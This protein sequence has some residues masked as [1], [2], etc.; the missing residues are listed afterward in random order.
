MTDQITDKYIDECKQIHQNAL[1]TAQ[2]HHDRAQFF[3][4]LAFWLQLVPAV[5]AALTGALVGSGVKSE[6]WLWLTVIAAV[7]SAVA[8][9]LNPSKESDEHARAAKSFTTLRHDARFLHEARVRRLS[10]EEFSRETERLHERYN[11]VVDM[12]PTTGRYFF[13]QARKFIRLGRHEPD[14]NKDGLI[15]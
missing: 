4:W 5:I 9:V 10:T 3:K 14:R 11:D 2:S 13:E 8:S 6:K 15:K 12:A 1:Y 7:V